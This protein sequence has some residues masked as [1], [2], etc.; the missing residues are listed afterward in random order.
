MTISEARLKQLTIGPSR[1]RTGLDRQRKDS[2][3]R[4]AFR[5]AGMRR[6]QSGGN[7]LRFNSTDGQNKYTKTL[8]TSYPSQ[9]SYARDMIPEKE[10]ERMYGR[11][12]RSTRDRALYLRRLRRQLRNTRTQRGVHNVDI[13]PTGDFKKNDS[14]EMVSRGKEF[15][16]VVREVPQEI[17]NSGG[18]KGDKIVGKA[19]EVMSG[20][21]S[22]PE[23]GRRKRRSLY[24]KALGASK[25]DP[26]TRI[27]VATVKE[28]KTFQE[29]IELAEKYHP[30]HKPLPGSRLTP[31]QKA[32]QKNRKRARTIASQ[33]PKNQERWATQYDRTQT[34]VKHGAD[35]PQLNTK[36]S[37]KDRNDLHIDSDDTGMDVYH[38][39]SGVFYRVERP[40]DA[41]DSD[42]HTIEWGHDKQKVSRS[43][44][45]KEKLKIARNA[46]RVW[47]QHISHRLP[48]RSIVHNTPVNSYDNRG[49]I[50]PV[51]RRS[52]IYKRAGF[53]PVDH[54]GDQFAEVGR[55]KSSK[56]KAKGNR[57]RLSPLS[58]YLTKMNAGWGRNDDYDED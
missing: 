2:S 11:G 53:G 50:K 3:E 51:N 27:Q 41:P 23:E 4:A 43:L 35:N 15:H 31:V 58:P 44:S 37:Y 26:V 55:E 32:E 12:V 25:W 18:K 47:D 28:S 9:S 56:Q 36:V 13:L 45:P 30:P 52:E 20:P 8:I 46:Q 21:S 10:K 1:S 19:S 6:T 42:V 39:P 49:N 22:N 7:R 14:R 48:H 34:K 5:R 24:S 38:K 17:V 57:S 33:S 16:R 29:F 40:D 54:E